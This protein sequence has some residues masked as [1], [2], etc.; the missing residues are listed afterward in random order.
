MQRPTARLVTPRSVVLFNPPRV[1]HLDKFGPVFELLGLKDGEGVTR[2]K[3]DFVLNL[4]VVA[5]CACLHEITLAIV[6]GQQVP[7]RCCIDLVVI[8]A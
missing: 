4:V 6:R 8:K 1:A 2:R 7:Q 3:P 5:W